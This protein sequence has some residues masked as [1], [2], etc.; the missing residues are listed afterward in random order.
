LDRFVSSPRTI[1]V[2]F[3]A[4]FSFSMTI[5]TRSVDVAVGCAVAHT[6]NTN[7]RKATVRTFTSSLYADLYQSS[8][9]VGGNRT[10]HNLS[11]C[12]GSDVVR[13]VN[14]HQISI[15]LQPPEYTTHILPLLMRHPPP[16]TCYNKEVAKKASHR[17][18]AFAL[19]SRG[20]LSDLSTLNSKIWRDFLANA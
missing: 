3:T 15:R 18:E 17:R 12:S 1:T 5:L 9:I 4:Y 11:A 16:P 20:I 6:T 19:S 7:P 10:Y 2:S 8:T 14:P 13:D